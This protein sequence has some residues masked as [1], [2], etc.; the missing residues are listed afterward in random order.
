MRTCGAPSASWIRCGGVVL[1]QAFSVHRMSF[2]CSRTKH[3]RSILLEID[4]EKREHAILL[5]QSLTAS[6][7][8]R[9][10]FDTA[11]PRSNTSL[12]PG[13]PPEAVRPT[14]S[15]LL[16]TVKLDD[17]DACDYDDYDKLQLPNFVNF[18]LL[19]K[20]VLDLRTPCQR[21]SFPVL[22]FT[23]LEAQDHQATLVISSHLFASL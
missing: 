9:I 22:H 2:W 21:G 16:T 19:R 20:G 5:F 14:C 10:Q 7:C 12:R 11:I 3:T 4:R 23:L 8:Q 15:T 17:H 18:L 6:A 13:I 1:W